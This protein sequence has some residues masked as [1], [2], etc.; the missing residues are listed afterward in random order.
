MHRLSVIEDD[1][2]LN[3]NKINIGKLKKE[4]LEAINYMLK[5]VKNIFQFL[6]AV[7]SFIYII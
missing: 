3:H 7:K 1:I 6:N 4:A 5:K 2:S